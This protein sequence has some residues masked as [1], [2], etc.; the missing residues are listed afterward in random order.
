MNR[1]DTEAFRLRHFIDDLVEAGE[2]E[3]VDQPTDL[4]DVAAKLDCNTK[5]VWFRAAG[6]ERAELVGNVMGSRR[7]LALA[8]DT[9]EKGFPGRLRDAIEHP[10]APVEIPTS[11]APVQLDYLMQPSGGGWKIEDVYLSGTISE[12]ARRRSEFTAVLDRGGPQALVDALRK[13]A[14]GENG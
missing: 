13:K 5:A 8:L 7:R 4:I 11:D 9:D 14:V 12:L 2:C 6:P 10:I 1:T 3:T